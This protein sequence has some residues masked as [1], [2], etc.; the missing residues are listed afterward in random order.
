MLPIRFA[1]AIGLIL[2]GLCTPTWAQSLM[3][4]ATISDSTHIDVGLGEIIEIEIFA[5]LSGY[6]AAG[7]SL[8]V[9]LPASPFSIVDQGGHAKE[10]V[11]PWLPGSLFAGA[12]E[13]ENCL[14]TGRE[15]GL[16]HN[17]QLLAYS[18]ILGPGKNRS[19]CGNGVVGRFQFMSMEPIDN[20]RI[21]VFSN[22]VH[23]SFLVLG[24]GL[25]ERRFRGVQ[26]LE[27][28]AFRTTLVHTRDS[29]GAIKTRYTA[30]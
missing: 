29:W 18:L 2:L 27:V 11:R 22:P 30:D 15:A 10:G 20:A 28:S 25:T 12:M 24:D 17:Q 19:R 23:D 4:E 21:E 9:R 14:V 8:Y 7:I 5:D 3:V 16:S 6:A 13:T 1:F 26:D